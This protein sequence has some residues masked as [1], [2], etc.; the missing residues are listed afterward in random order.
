MERKLSEQAYVIT[1]TTMALKLLMQRVFGER[2]S[3]EL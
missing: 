3:L 1:P 2:A